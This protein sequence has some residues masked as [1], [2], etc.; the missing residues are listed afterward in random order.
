MGQGC[1]WGLAPR[2]FTHTGPGG[3]TGRVTHLSPREA[4]VP[5]WPPAHGHPLS[6]P[7]NDLTP[8]WLSL[9]PA[10]QLSGRPHE[11]ALNSLPTHPPQG[12]LGLVALAWHSRFPRGCTSTSSHSHIP[13][14][15]PTP[16]DLAPQLTALA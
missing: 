12:V 15:N 8:I 4:E 5:L 16:N 14:A 3:H 7:R 10:Y 13:G 6:F 9:P 1:S 2:Q 11:S